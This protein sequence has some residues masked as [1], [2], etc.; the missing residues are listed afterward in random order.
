MKIK[1]FY[2]SQQASWVETMD[3]ANRVDK[4]DPG[5]NQSFLT[6]Q[7]SHLIPNP[8][9]DSVSSVLFSKDSK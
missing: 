1:I 6:G 5:N 2:V 7:I 3:Y 4:G 9:N 8:K